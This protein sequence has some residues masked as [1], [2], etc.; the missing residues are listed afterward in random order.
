MTDSAFQH[1]DRPVAPDH[2]VRRPYRPPVGLPTRGEGRG[3]RGLLVS[4]VIHAAL[5]AALIVPALLTGVI[6]ADML[7]RGGDGP[8][9]GGGGGRRGAGGLSSEPERLQFVRIAPT[10]PAVTPAVP[11]PVP[12]PPTPVVPPPQATP[13]QPPPAVEAPP[14]PAGGAGTGADATSGNGTGT[15]GGTGTGTGTGSGSATGAGTGGDGADHD[16]PVVTNLA[17]LPI[18]V[19]RGVRPYRM[20]AYFDVDEKGNA[21]LLTFNPSSDGGYNRRIRDMLAEIRFRPAVRRDGTP[22]RDT[23]MIVAEAP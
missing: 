18:P 16:P 21:K 9:G 10:P 6:D 3:W 15:G 7:T 2:G 8:R 22:V 20:V 1:P 13:P 17:I 19:P 14:S 12:P 4:V 5:I 23:A 11:P